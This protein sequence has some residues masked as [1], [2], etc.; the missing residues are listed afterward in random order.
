MLVMA[1]EFRCGQMEPGMKVIGRT[2]RRLVVA[3]LLMWMETSTMES[4]EMIRLVEEGL[5]F[6]AMVPG[7]KASGW[8]TTSMDM[9]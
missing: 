3:D 6:T 4:G 5:T 9:E 7:M 2:E 8:M 1:M